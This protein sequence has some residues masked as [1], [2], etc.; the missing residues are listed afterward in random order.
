M[1]CPGEG[2]EGEEEEEEEEEE[3]DENQFYTTVEL[4]SRIEKWL[5]ISK[6][7]ITLTWT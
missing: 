3:E 5:I 6:F 1:I 2:E 7:A 4:R